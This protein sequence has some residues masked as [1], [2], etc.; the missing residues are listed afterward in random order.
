[1]S[2]WTLRLKSEFRFTVSKCKHF[3]VLL[4]VLKPLISRQMLQILSLRP[5]KTTDLFLEH[6]SFFSY[7]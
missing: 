5:V 2:Q 4:E 6:S 7:L 3:S 1:M